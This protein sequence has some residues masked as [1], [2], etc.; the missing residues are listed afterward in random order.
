MELKVKELDIAL[1]RARDIEKVVEDKDNS[2]NALKAQRRA[3][4]TRFL[5]IRN[6]IDN[7]I[8]DYK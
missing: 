7:L 4:D 8:F 3:A 2:I 5:V 1:E 6:L